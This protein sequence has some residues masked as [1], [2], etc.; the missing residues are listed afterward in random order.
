VPEPGG[1][2]FDNT[3]ILW[4]NHMEEGHTHNSQKTPWMLAGNVGNYFRMGQCVNSTGK[5]V[6]GVL[7]H[8]CHALG[9]PV[10]T[11]GTPG[12]GGAMDGLAA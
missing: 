6:N 11:F 10:Q 5:P 2:M 4:A 1:T 3:V 8:L 7:W 12:F 9:M